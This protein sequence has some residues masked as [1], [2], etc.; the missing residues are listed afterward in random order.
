MTYP[1][2]PPPPFIIVDDNHEDLFILKRLLTRAD[3]KNPFISFD[4]GEEAVRFLLAALR[5]PESQLIP[6][7]I[8]SDKAM[9]ERS[10]FELLKWVRE[11]PL[12][13][14]TPFVMFTSV[15]KPGEAKRARELG[16]SRFYE[17]YPAQHII[18]E[19]VGEIVKPQSIRRK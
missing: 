18:E 15:A 2:T 10:G 14:Q 4:H 5:T 3:A 11:Q 17:K 6:A 9:P 1:V 8:F 16:A 13:Q 19:I 7:A 12:L